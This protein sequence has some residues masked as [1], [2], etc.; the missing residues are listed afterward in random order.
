MTQF[1][2]SDYV[3]SRMRHWFHSGINGNINDGIS[4]TLSLQL[5]P[6][7]DGVSPGQA[8]WY[9]YHGMGCPYHE[10]TNSLPF[11]VARSLPDGTGWYTAY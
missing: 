6:S 10:G 4:Q 11:V 7:P 2:A 3:K 5:E 9:S 8:T 1:T